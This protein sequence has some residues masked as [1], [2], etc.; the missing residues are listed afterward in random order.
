MGSCRSKRRSTRGLSGILRPEL[1]GTSRQLR[2][3][4]FRVC[5]WRHRQQLY[6]GP[7]LTY[8]VATTKIPPSRIRLAFLFSVSFF[9]LICLISLSC[10]EM[11]D[12]LLHPR[13]I[14]A[15]RLLH[16]GSRLLAISHGTDGDRSFFSPGSTSLFALCA[17]VLLRVALAMVL[18]AV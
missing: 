7:R 8:I 2:T 14:Y 16:L 9:A 12:Q 1:A 5:S 11:S 4:K 3:C 17:A 6:D 15:T 10:S 13:L 18:C